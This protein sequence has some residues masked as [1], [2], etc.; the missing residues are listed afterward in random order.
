MS[1]RI[2]SLVARLSGL[3]GCC[4]HESDT[5]LLQRFARRGEA[6]GFEALVD[7][8][9]ALVW[10]VCQRTADHDVDRE[11]AF[12]ATFL[13]LLQRASSLDANTPLGGWLHTVALRV[14]L[15]ARA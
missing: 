8:Y 6:A 15:K 9:A 2:A 5:E 3:C 10:G 1:P 13:A 4:I 14:S 12:Q 7:R 11:D